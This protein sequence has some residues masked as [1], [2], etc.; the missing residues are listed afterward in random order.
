MI[1][2]IENNKLKTD[3]LICI[4]FAISKFKVIFKIY[5]NSKTIKLISI[6]SNSMTD[7]DTNRIVLNEFYNHFDDDCY[8]ITIDE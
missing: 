6:L 3:K 7:F 4:T 5:A 1:Q 2:R 8:M